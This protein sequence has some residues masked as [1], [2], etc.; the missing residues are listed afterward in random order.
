MS[1][2][3]RPHRTWT[4]KG[5]RI[6]L[7]FD[8]AKRMWWIYLDGEA[9]GGQ[10]GDE[11]YEPRVANEAYLLAGRKATDDKWRVQIHA[12]AAEKF[13]VAGRG[14][15]RSTDK[16]GDPFWVRHLGSWRRGIVTAAKMKTIEVSFLEGEYEIVHRLVHMNEVVKALV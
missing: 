6:D 10:R 14:F 9:K 15:E 16:V 2:T 3:S 13:H 8:V 1:I 7:Y 12:V 5:V 11:D 4:Y